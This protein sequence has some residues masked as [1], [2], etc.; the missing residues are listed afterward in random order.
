MLA[1][2]AKVAEIIAMM[3]RLG[4]VERHPRLGR[5]AKRPPSEH[6]QRRNF[7]S[8]YQMNLVLDHPIG[9]ARP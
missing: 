7:Q 6:G 8:K 1:A 9:G 3:L 2:G 4:W 5:L